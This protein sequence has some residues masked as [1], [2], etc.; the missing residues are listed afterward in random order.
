MQQDESQLRLA[1]SVSGLAD[2][3][4]LVSA[5]SLVTK[6]QR[7]GLFIVLFLLIVGVVLSARMTFT[8]VIA[9]LHHG[10]SPG[11]RLPGLPLPAVLE[12]LMRSRW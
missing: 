8:I 10:L 2:R 4:P 3:V 5:R 12:E 7:N 1:A 9:I 6:G 11:G